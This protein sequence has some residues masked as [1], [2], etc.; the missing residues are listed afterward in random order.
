[1]QTSNRPAAWS[2]L[3]SFLTRGARAYLLL[4]S[5]C[6]LLP[7]GSIARTHSSQVKDTRRHHYQIQLK[8][9]FDALSYAGS[10]RVR[11]INHSCKP[12]CETEEDGGR[13]FIKVLRNIAAGEELFYDYGLVIDGRYTA[14]LMAEYPCWCGAKSCRGTLLAPKKRKARDSKDSQDSEETPKNKKTKG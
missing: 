7:P 6:I 8:L 14:K 13:V 11:W 2:R 12:N 3:R 10:E 5:L 9:D 1:M 4:I